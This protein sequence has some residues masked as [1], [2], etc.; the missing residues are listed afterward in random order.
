MPLYRTQVELAM[1]SGNPDDK[2]TNVWHFIAD[3]LTALDLALTQVT[4][5]YAAIDGNL[6]ALIAAT[7]H[8]IRCYDLAD[9]KPRAPVRDQGAGTLSLGTGALPP[10]LALCM[11]FQ[12]PRQS[13]VSQA[14]RRG[15][16]YLG[17]LSSTAYTTSTGFP[18]ST[19]LTNIGNAVQNLLDASQAA[20]TWAWA[21]YSP[22]TETAIEVNDAWVDNAF[23]I[24]RRRGVA[25]T[26]R[27]LFT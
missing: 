23:D 25:A 1:T 9:T 11:S 12:A 2:A 24:Q 10:E 8:R 3:D 20:T 5:F 7:G 15:R 17:P 6:S 16:L 13:G 22:T 26:S 18:T 27:A 14:R 21:V 4:T 19:I